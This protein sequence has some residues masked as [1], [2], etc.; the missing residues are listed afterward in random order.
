MIDPTKHYLTPIELA[1]RLRRPEGTIR[2]WRH[3]RFGPPWI[4]LGKE[5]LYPLDGVE[6]WEQERL[7]G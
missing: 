1:A 2:N 4:K 6:K 5:V 7:R 3:R